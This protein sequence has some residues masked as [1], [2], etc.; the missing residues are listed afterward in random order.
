[1]GAETFYEKIKSNSM[2]QGYRD[3][4]ENAQFEAGHDSYNGTISTTSGY[5]DVTNDFKRSNLSLDKFIDLN[6]DKCQ[7]W[8]NAWGICI[9]EP[10]TN[11]N[12]IKT[13]VEHKVFKGTRKWVLYYVVYNFMGDKNLGVK[14]LKA[15]AIKIAREHTE[16]TQQRTVINIEK[17]L[18]KSNSL[19][20]EIS[21]KGSS[22][23]TMG[24]YVFF[25][26]AAS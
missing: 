26:L 9:T 22:S 7:K 16:K 17:H 12:K 15:D 20:A 2:T 24:E 23:D 19:V 11:S 14:R 21:Y 5:K 10:K 4:V 6:I 1:M 13:Q 8:G 18:E 25:G 3:A